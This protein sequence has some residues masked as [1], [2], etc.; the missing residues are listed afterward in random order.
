MV[1]FEAESF[2]AVIDKGMTDSVMYNDKFALMM[3]K[4]GDPSHSGCPDVEKNQFLRFVFLRALGSQTF[5]DGEKQYF[6]KQRRAL[7]HR[8]FTCAVV[9][10]N[11]CQVLFP[12]STD[13]SLLPITF[14]FHVNDKQA[15]VHLFVY[16][17]IVRYRTK[18]PAC[19][20]R[21]GCIC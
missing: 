10:A 16:R 6:F 4:V 20:S 21:E 19:S 14:S 3:A 15:I 2:D 1:D 17:L 5:M 13:P 11:L 18:L 7:H 9:A 8:L 12:T